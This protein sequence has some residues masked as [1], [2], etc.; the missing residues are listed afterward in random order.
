ML[1]VNAGMKTIDK[2]MKVLRVFSCERTEI[3][4]SEIARLAQEDKATV[5]RIL[6]SL[7]QHEIIEQHPGTRKYRLGAACLRLAR[8]REASFPV[9]SIVPPVLERLSEQ[10]GETAHAAVPCGDHLLTIGVRHA[11]RATRVNLD[12]AECLPLHAT[13]SGIVFLAFAD[14]QW[15]EAYLAGEL[16]SYTPHTLTDPARIRQAVAA[17][18]KT[19]YG[20]SA[21]GYEEEVV[22]IAAPFFHEATVAGTL[23][24]ATPAS[25]MTDALAD[26]I[27]HGLRES[28]LQVTEELGGEVPGAYRTACGQAA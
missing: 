15:V 14:P 23:G 27:R 24:V 17:A 8:I 16:K 6:V 1:P 22:G 13:A 28:V 12:H 11:A 7:Q 9:T 26:K 25:R 20:I 19:G 4:L 10:C 3:G 2:A 5:R 18:R 21:Q